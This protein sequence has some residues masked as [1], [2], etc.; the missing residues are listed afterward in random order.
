MIHLVWSG[1]GWLVAVIVFGSSLTANLIANY[2]TGGRAYWNDHKWPLAVSFFVS[3]VA[4]WFLGD[5]LK[6][7]KAR[8][9]VDRETGE[10]V[11]L[12]KSHTLFYVPVMWWGPILAALSIIALGYDLFRRHG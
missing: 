5:F 10:E 6:Y 1:Q 4:C 11:V 8:V 12:G 3:G 2:V 7:R 9:L